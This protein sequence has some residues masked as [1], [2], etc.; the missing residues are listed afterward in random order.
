MVTHHTNCVEDQAWADGSTK[1]YKI[2][3]AMLDDFDRQDVLDLYRLVKERFKITSPKGCDRLLWG[4]LITLFK[5]NLQDHSLRS[6]RVLGYILFVKI[7]LLIKKLED[8]KVSTVGE[9]YRKYSKSSLLLV[10]KLLLLVLVTTAR[11][12]SDVSYKSP[13][14]GERLYAG[15]RREKA[16]V[17]GKIKVVWWSFLV[18]KPSSSEDVSKMFQK[19]NFRFLL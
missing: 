19:F 14:S 16:D 15:R 12:V 13:C 7:K 4:D 8:S 5:P 1:F 11:R 6:R 9:D 3:T 2:F 17:A 18:T 10:V